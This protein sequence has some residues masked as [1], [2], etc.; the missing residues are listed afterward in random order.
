M[1][2]RPSM[3]E[4]LQGLVAEGQVDA[5]VEAR[6]RT[7]LE[8]RQRTM[9]ASPWFVKALSGLGAWMSAGFLMSFFACVGLWDEEGVL[10]VL[11]VVLC[12]ASVYLRRE[13]EGPFMEQLGLSTCLAGAGS[14]L[15]AVAEWTNN[16]VT[17]AL[18]A[19]GLGA[20]MLAYFPDVVLYFLATLGICLSLG[21]LAEKALSGM[22][23]DLCVVLGSA[24]LCG[25]LIFEPRLRKG[26][27]GDRVGPM[28]FALACAVPGWLLFRNLVGM[29]DGF[30][31]LFRGDFLPPVAL[32]VPLAAIALWTGW[33]VLREQGL[34][35]DRGVWLPAVLALVLLT[36]MT[37]STPGLL[38]AG[39]MLTLGFHRRSRVM[40]GLAVAFLLTFGSFYYYDLRLTLLAKALA[41]VGSG[42]VLLGV[43]QFFQRRAPAVLAEAR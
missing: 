19:V 22:G 1:A 16:D 4:V 5:E 41:L 14:I 36:G 2:L 8:V 32:T 23:V 31:Y 6:A 20:L 10:L 37:L 11:G 42:L 34:D 33:Q 25:L 39:L 7:A 26:A 17:V 38:V 13:L 27:L 3:R 15:F 40:L 12:G 24:A 9:N 43:R 30:H 21:F 29:Q 35:K 18:T 28:A